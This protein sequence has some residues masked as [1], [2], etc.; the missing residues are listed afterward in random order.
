[1]KTANGKEIPFEPPSYEGDNIVNLMASILSATGGRS[2]YAELHCLDTQRLTNAQHIVLL[3]IDGLGFE[4]LQSCSAGEAMRAHLKSSMTSVFPPTTAS[5]VTTYLTGLAPRQ[6]GLTGWFMY[7]KELDTV[8]TVLPFTTRMGARPLT[9]LGVTARSLLGH[10]PVFDAIDRN[11]FSVSPAQIAHSEFN[12]AHTG[13]AELKP[14]D[15]LLDFFAAIEDVV[16]QT[17]G[18]TFTY[19]YWPEFDH[20][21]H[22]KGVNSRAVKKHLAELDAGFEELLH[23]LKGTD[24]MLLVTADHGFVDI[25]PERIV[26]V[27]DHPDL[28]ETLRLPLCGEPRAAYCYVPSDW[29][30]AFLDYVDS[31][32]S[33][34]A[35]CIESEAL[36]EQGYFGPGVS[37]PGLRDRVGDYTLLMRD[38]YAIHDTMPGE[39]PPAMI[40]M[41]GG[42]S[43]AELQGT[44]DRRGGLRPGFAPLSRPSA[45]TSTFAATQEF[46]LG[47]PKCVSFT[48][49]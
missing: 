17:N 26:S 23:R 12:R 41:H 9:E 25:S 35:V 24:T 13:K 27:S 7:F 15:S 30:R 37:H 33:E 19:A 1:M 8:T 6:H 42:C 11:C 10:V 20:L 5:A 31:E 39:Q 40:G 18:K 21:S 32:L 34:Y 49:Q 28:R 36:I 29:R 45:Q 48:M 2:Q 44:A 14:Y 4:F 47:V 46:S 3:V 43:S 38:G 16:E 22:V